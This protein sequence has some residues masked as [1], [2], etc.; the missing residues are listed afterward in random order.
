[1]FGEGEEGTVESAV[2][3]KDNGVGAQM[4][5]QGQDAGD[6]GLCCSCHAVMGELV[7]MLDKGAV[8]ERK[9]GGCEVF[10]VWEGVNVDASVAWG[11]V[12]GDLCNCICTRL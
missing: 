10:G 5:A 7:T 6:G 2:G 12:V 8:N 9:E 4:G 1:M 11:R 3:D